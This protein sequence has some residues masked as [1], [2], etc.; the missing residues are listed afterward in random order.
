LLHALV[1]NGGFATTKSNVF[2]RPVL[3]VKCGLARVL[4]FQISAVGQSCSIMF[5]RARAAVALS[6]SCP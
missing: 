4:S 1:E 6:I 2:S 5:I 3:T